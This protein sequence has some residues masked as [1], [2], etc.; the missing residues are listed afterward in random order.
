MLLACRGRVVPGTRLCARCAFDL[1]GL[2]QATLCPECG[3]HLTGRRAVV[4]RRVRS[5]LLIALSLFLA[6][7]VLAASGIWIIARTSRNA[8]NPYKPLWWLK[9]EAHHGSPKTSELAL[10]EILTRMGTNSMRPADEQ[11]LGFD[12]FQRKKNNPSAWSPSWSDVLAVARAHG[13]V[14]DADWTEYARLSLQLQTRARSRVRQ[15]SPTTIRLAMSVPGVSRRT[16]IS[17]GYTIESM[18]LGGKHLDSD[19]YSGSGTFGATTLFG[20]TFSP[21][22]D[23]PLGPSE[24][25]I[26]CR[27]ESFAALD[28]TA[29]IGSWT[30]NLTVPV[31]V[32]SPDAPLVEARPESASF[33]SVASSLSIQPVLRNK[34]PIVFVQ[35]KSAPANLAFDVFVRF[36]DGDG[37]LIPAERVSFLAGATESQGTMP[38]LDRWPESGSFD[39]ILKPSIAGAEANPDF[40]WLWTG[41]DILFDSVPMRERPLMPPRPE[42]G[43]SSAPRP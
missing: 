4:E 7:G 10:I 39:V 33:Q 43:S 36:R 19:A 11:A 42:A 5:R 6:L 34:S 26:H 22:C 24:F 2:V 38:K 21:V 20:M 40:D 18:T 23:A 41:P 37:T 15:G 3:Q 30:R 28:G 35:C 9:F 17:L 8:L 29:P 14:S 13:Q 16:S 1:A 32:V 31:T 25:E 12:A 27:I